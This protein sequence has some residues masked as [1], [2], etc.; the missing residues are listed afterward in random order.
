MSSSSKVFPTIASCGKSS[1]QTSPHTSVPHLAAPFCPTAMDDSEMERSEVSSQGTATP[2][3][4]AS[5]NLMMSGL[6]LGSGNLLSGHALGP[7]EAFFPFHSIGADGKMV[8]DE[9]DADEDDDDDDGED[10]LNIEDFIDFG[11]DSEDSDHDNGS[12]TESFQSPKVLS[13]QTDADATPTASPSARSS[14]PNLYEHLNRGKVTAFRRNQY[15]HGASI[16]R[17]SSSSAFQIPNAIKSNA[18]VAA[19]SFGSLKKRKLSEDFGPSVANSPA[20]AKRRI[21]DPN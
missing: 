11:E 13:D 2:M 7:P 21:V 4:S 6:G 10:L 14:P 16:Y 5:P 17:P 9:L 18:F 19:S 3:L 8:H 12:N 15:D 1:L 20:F